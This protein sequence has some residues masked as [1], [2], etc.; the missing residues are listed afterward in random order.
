MKHIKKGSNVG[1]IRTA[2]NISGGVINLTGASITATFKQ[3][4]NATTNLFVKKN[5]AAGGG[6][7]EI[8]VHS[9]DYGIY[10]TKILPANTISL[11][12]KLLFC[13]VTIVIG[14]NTDVDMFYVRIQDNKED[15]SATTSAATDTSSFLSRG[16]TAE[17]TAQGL[18]LGATDVFIWIDTTENTT[19]SWNGT[20]WI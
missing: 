1:I 17:R 7:T 13:L 11:D 5:T 18:L 15:T 4:A 3:S 14:A 12:Y 16:T 20:R 2:K 8:Q 10:E 6:D 19:Y 9:E